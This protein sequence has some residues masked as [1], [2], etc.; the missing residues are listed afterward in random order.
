MKKTILIIINL[1]IFL[2]NLAFANG[3]PFNISTFQ[4]TGNIMLMNY[5]NV[6]LLSEDLY[7]KLN[8]DYTTVKVK[9]KLKNTG[10]TKKIWYGFPV[11][12]YSSYDSPMQPFQADDMYE[13]GYIVQ[14]FKASDNSKPLRFIYFSNDTSSTFEPEGTIYRRW[15][16][17]KINF[18]K[19]EIK[20]LNI[21]Y[22]VRNSSWDMS[23][24]DRWLSKYS[25]RNFNYDFKPAGY[26]A[27]GVVND[28]SVTI[29]FREQIKKKIPFSVKGL[30]GLK[31]TDSLYQLK[32][33]NYDLKKAENLNIRYNYAHLKL[34]ETIKKRHI[35]YNMIRSIKTSSNT[36]NAKYLID[37]DPTTVWQGKKGDW[38][39]IDFYKYGNHW[40]EDPDDVF[41]LRAV[42]ALNGDFSSKTNYNNSGKAKTIKIYFNQ[43]ILL[44]QDYRGEKTTKK[45][46]NTKYP[47]FNKKDIKGRASIFTDSNGLYEWKAG[48]NDWHTY[49]NK[50]GYIWRIKIYVQDIYPAK[51]NADKFSISEMYFI[52]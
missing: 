44:R 1:S 34:A 13:G 10:N 22:K 48:K 2:V 4:K 16:V 8:G 32:V 42:L 38:I 14:Y 23:L 6:K 12:A 3:G 19:D 35:P 37:N 41:K 11:D 36:E 50:D 24:G 20:T 15:Y 9:Y 31:Q 33:K 25:D 52:W 5:A 30:E 49:R 51:T 46:Q 29:D 18:E 40:T 39:Q 27:D 21:E 43:G 47:D 17:V 28:F 26:W 7:I 45:L